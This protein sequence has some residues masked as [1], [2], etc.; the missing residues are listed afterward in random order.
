MNDS[1]GF[2]GCEQNNLIIHFYYAIGGDLS[3]E[4]FS[5]ARQNL[6]VII[7]QTDLKEKYAFQETVKEMLRHEETQNAK[8]T[9]GI[10]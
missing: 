2:R 9:D 1:S 3:F 8:K 5:R 4:C 7:S 6:I 10:N